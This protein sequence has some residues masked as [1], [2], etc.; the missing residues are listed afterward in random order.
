MFIKKGMTVRVIS[1][2]YKGQEGKVLFVFPKRQRVIV[3][4]IN[5][6]KRHTRPSQDNP[7]GGIVE[8]EA[9]VHI[10]N[11]MVVHGGKPTRVGY[12]FLEDGT[13]VRISR[14]TGEEIG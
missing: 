9:A 6:I 1:G 12:K 14:K 10:S 4:G 8:K 5:F 7:Q 13:K 2:N 11:L 3:E